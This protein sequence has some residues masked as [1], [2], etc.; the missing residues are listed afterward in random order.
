MISGF[1]FF[2]QAASVSPSGYQALRA[3]GRAYVKHWGRIG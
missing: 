1:K 2:L 3:G